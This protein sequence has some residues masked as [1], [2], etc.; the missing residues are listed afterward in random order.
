[1]GARGSNLLSVRRLVELLRKVVVFCFEIIVLAQKAEACFVTSLICGVRDGNIS[2]RRGRTTKLELLEFLPRRLEIS[3]V[4][5]AFKLLH[6]L[7]VI[8]FGW[9]LF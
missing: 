3:C 2:Q 6:G 8:L 7:S 9:F 1:V 5:V 4:H